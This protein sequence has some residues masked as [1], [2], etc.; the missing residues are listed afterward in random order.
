MMVEVLISEMDVEV[1]RVSVE[2]LELKRLYNP[3][4]MRE[5]LT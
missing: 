3:L 1:V 2:G 4:F 5:E